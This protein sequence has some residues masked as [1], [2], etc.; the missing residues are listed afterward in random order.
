[1]NNKLNFNGK[2]DFSDIDLT[3]PD[4]VIEE[5][6]AQLPRE[7]N[8]IIFGK[9]QPYDGPVFSYKTVG[10]AGM[11]EALGTVSQNVDIQD[12]LGEIGQED[13]KFEC[14]LYTSEYDKYKYRVFFVQYDVANY[15]VSIILDESVAESIS[16]VNRGYV[17]RCDT[18]EELEKLIY[19]IFGSKRI[20]EVMQELVRI[21]QVKRGTKNNRK[22]ENVVY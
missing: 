15:P 19:G 3:A 12:K 5:I 20:M 4:K 7:T 18:R 8:E 10:F 14:F 9:I 11:A 1:M 17:Y 2:L 22:A 6:L 16:G 21:S 13:Y